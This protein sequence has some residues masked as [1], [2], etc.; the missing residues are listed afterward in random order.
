M[1][2]R[3]RDTLGGKMWWA[4]RDRGL[5][6]EAVA[7][8]V[9]RS[10]ATVDRW[11]RDGRKPSSEDLAKFA[12]LVGR[13]LNYFHGG[14]DRNVER[15]MGLIRDIVDYL[16]AGKSLPEAIE[17]GADAEGLIRDDAE[18]LGL[19]AASTLIRQ[20]LQERAGREWD[21]LTTA[22]K[23]AVL[24]DLVARTYRNNRHR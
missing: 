21:L 7:K 20:S 17:R 4:A 8:G 22:E 3:S 10:K 16:M 1:K 13:D 11:F 24:A 15:L 2:T 9:G 23:D 5:T 18:R 14:E 12:E 19:A 6:L